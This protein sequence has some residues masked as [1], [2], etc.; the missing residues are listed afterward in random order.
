MAVWTSTTTA[1]SV[2]A[3][4]TPSCQVFLGPTASVPQVHTV[5]DRL[6]VKEVSVLNTFGSLF[7]KD[8]FLPQLN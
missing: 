8:S 6:P 7:F 2:A 3:K 5:R 4:S 1:N